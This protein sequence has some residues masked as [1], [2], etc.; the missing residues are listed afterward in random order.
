MVSGT[1]EN[2]AARTG[3]VSARNGSPIGPGIG[4]IDVEYTDAKGSTEG[5]LEEALRRASKAERW[6]V[7]AKL[8]DELRARR[9]AAAGNVLPLTRAKKGGA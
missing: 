9:E 8:A 7:V 4:P 3:S 2:D 6:D 5:A 1:Y